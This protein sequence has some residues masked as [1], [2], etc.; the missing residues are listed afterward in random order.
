MGGNNNDRPLASIYE[1][2][3]EAALES[4]YDSWADK[5]DADTAAG[6]YRLPF[7]VAAFVARYLPATDA[8]ILDAGAGTGLAGDGLRVLGY[9]NITGIDLSQKMLD[10]A[11][12][13]KVY[14]RLERMTLGETLAFH[15]DLFDGVIST[16]V[17]TE[18][19]AP[20]SSFD[21]L[22]RV[23][24]PGGHIIFTVR[25]DVYL[26]KGFKE[27]QSALEADGAWK[28][29]EMTEPVRAYTISEA[30]IRAIFFVYEVA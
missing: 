25:D 16:G 8:A 30:H 29:I 18:G 11:A 5:Y 12:S 14:R 4:E 3:D 26:E 15:S 10:R 19:H 28:L 2:G 1:A 7:L 21:E 27:K 6:G 23:T 9:G 24:R 13:L 20:P 22:V 17:F